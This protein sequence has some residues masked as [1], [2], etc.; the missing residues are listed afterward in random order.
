MERNEKL[1]GTYFISQKFV[2]RCTLF[3]AQQLLAHLHKDA[4]KNIAFVFTN[5]RSTFY[6]PGDT[7]P[8]LTLLLE[9]FKNVKIEALEKNM[10][11][12]DNE[13]FRFLACVLQ[14]VQLSTNCFNFLFICQS[15]YK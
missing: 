3:Y 8:N 13:A 1:S 15:E 6:Q 14:G 12:F 11:C 7:L 9:K 10:F 5:S 2:W 4:A